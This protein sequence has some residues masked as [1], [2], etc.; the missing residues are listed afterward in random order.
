MECEL[1]GPAFT[2]DGQSLLIAVQHPGELHGPRAAGAEETRTLRI[3]PR[4]GPPPF[5][6]RRLVPLGSNF[7]GGKP[8]DVPRSCVVCVTRA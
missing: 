7:P 8:G 6:Q 4:G 2:P 3:A 5:D 1:T